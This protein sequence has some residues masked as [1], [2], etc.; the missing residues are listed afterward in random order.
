MDELGGKT[1]KY[2][3]TKRYIN[4]YTN[5]ERF[6]QGQ[7]LEVKGIRVVDGNGM[8]IFDVDSVTANRYGKIIE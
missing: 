7:T 1:V 6:K 5:K 8:W 3:F 2:L 4:K